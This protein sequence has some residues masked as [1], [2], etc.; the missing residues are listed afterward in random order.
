MNQKLQLSHFHL[1]RQM[2][3]YQK[4]IIKTYITSAKKIGG[5]IISVGCGRG[6]CLEKG[7][8]IPLYNDN[9]KK[10]EDLV[11]GDTLIGDDGSPRIILSL[12]SG[13]SPMFEVSTINNYNFYKDTINNNYNQIK[14][15]NNKANIIS[16]FKPYTVNQDH[17]LTLFRDKISNNK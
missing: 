3:D 2:R 15:Y 9:S 12:G 4:D 1:D 10:V 5:G 16:N 17:I 14:I 6:K 7:T 11:E 13:V 8:I